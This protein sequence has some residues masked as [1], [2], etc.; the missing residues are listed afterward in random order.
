MYFRFVL[1]EAPLC[2]SGGITDRIITCSASWVNLIFLL[3]YN[4]QSQIQEILA[5]TKCSGSPKLKIWTPPTVALVRL[6]FTLNFEYLSRRLYL[7]AKHQQI[8][9]NVS[10]FSDKCEILRQSSIKWPGT[11]LRIGGEGEKNR[12]GRKKKIGERSELRSIPGRGKGGTARAT[13]RRYFSYL[14]PL[15]GFFPHCRA[16]SQAKY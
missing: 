1:I 6:I 14:T 7:S 12:R 4:L 3:D 11:R 10:P 5:V 9:E 13:A 16:W 15:F 8:N 2:G